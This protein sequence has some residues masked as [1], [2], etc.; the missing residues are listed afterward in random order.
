MPITYQKLKE[1][2]VLLEGTLFK[3]FMTVTDGDCSKKPIPVDVAYLLDMLVAG[4]HPPLH[5][6]L[7]V[8]HPHSCYAGHED[9]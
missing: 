5:V 7:L 8:W 6:P 1:C 2:G 9:N 4:T 3:L